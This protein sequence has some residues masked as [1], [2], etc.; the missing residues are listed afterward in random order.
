MNHKYEVGI[1]E[2]S[3]NFSAGTLAKQANGA[4]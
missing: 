4:V 2:F 3:T 1:D